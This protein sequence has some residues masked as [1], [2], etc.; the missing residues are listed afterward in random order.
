MNDPVFIY[1]LTEPGTGN[2]RYVGKTY[3]VQRRYCVHLCDTTNTHKVHWIQS[4]IARGLKP[5]CK[6][7]EVVKPGDDWVSIERFWIKLFKDKGFKLTNLTDGG[8]GAPGYKHT[9]EA[10]QLFS[11]LHKGPRTADFCRKLSQV[12]VTRKFTNEEVVKIR[13][14]YAAGGILHR[15]LAEE[16]GVNKATIGKILRGSTYGYLDGPI[17]PKF[18]GNS[19]MA[20]E[21]AN[22]ILLE[23]L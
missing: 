19:S 10:K 18:V 17:Q 14:R 1:V 4:L 5:D 2:V 23:N 13:K 20:Y 6:V 12:N 22:K 7:I 21:R 15:E 11:K 16:Y 9:E 8:D 3:N